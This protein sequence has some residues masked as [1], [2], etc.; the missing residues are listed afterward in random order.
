MRSMKI[1]TIDATETG[2]KGVA[3]PYETEEQVQSAWSYM[4]HH[5]Y[6]NIRPGPRVDNQDR[7]MLELCANGFQKGEKLHIPAADQIRGLVSKI[8]QDEMSHDI[9]ELVDATH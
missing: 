8:R 5:E 1:L 4:F 7:A 9:R 3:L 6:V 2:R